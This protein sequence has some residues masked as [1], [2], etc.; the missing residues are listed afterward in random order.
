MSFWSKVVG[1]F[2]KDSVKAVLKIGIKLLKAF[3][4]AVAEKLQDVANEEVYKAELTG[5]DG[6]EKYK[7]ALKGVRSRFPELKESALN[8]AI[9]IAVNALTNKK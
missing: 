8:L 1:F 9:E 3:G 2:A 6:L 7:L 4:I 5:K